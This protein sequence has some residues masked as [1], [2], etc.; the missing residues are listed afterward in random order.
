MMTRH[1]GE[2]ARHERRKNEQDKRYARERPDI[3]EDTRK[4]ERMKRQEGVNQARK[5]MKRP[6][7]KRRRKWVQRTN[8]SEDQGTAR[9][10]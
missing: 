1:I 5:M 9:R 7:T 3:H 10:E 6:I 4:K 8:E 2:N